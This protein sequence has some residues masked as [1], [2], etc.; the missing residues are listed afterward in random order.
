MISQDWV[1]VGCDE[2]LLPIGTKP[3]PEAAF[4]WGQ[5]HKKYLN[6]QSLKFAWKLLI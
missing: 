2:D 5:F 4:N 1:I 3:L 6:N